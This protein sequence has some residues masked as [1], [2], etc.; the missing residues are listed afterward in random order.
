M[1]IYA[2]RN[3]KWGLAVSTL[4]TTYVIFVYYLGFYKNIL[5]A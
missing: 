3:S 1:L 5:T 4:A 2:F